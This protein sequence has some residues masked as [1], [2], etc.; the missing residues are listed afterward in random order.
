MIIDLDSWEIGYQDGQS[1][2]PYECPA[3]R[4]QVSY[5]SGY[6]QGSAA[7]GGAWWLPFVCATR[8]RRWGGFDLFASRSKAP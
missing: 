2:R 3:N 5:S 7:R 8:Y 4:D 1:G 6:R